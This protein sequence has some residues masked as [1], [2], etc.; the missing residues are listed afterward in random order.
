MQRRRRRQPANDKLPGGRRR[1]QR[2]VGPRGRRS[3]RRGCVE[4]SRGMAPHAPPRPSLCNIA[5]LTRGARP[6]YRP[7]KSGIWWHANRSIPVAAPRIDKWEL[8]TTVTDRHDPTLV[9]AA[10][11]TTPCVV[12]VLTEG[13]E[14]TDIRA[15]YLLG[16]LTAVLCPWSD[17][18]TM[19]WPVFDY[20]ARRDAHLWRTRGPCRILKNQRAAY[21]RFAADHSPYR[22]LSSST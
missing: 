20:C 16:L 7:G 21:A 15:R 2:S 5:T 4:K 8:A 19:K 11:P 1:R 10:T 14:A 6:R 13:Q 12:N 9:F 17:V 18:S 22:R 3:R